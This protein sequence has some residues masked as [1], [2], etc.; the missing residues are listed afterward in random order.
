MVCG[1][2]WA[3]DY[4]C[5]RR[6]SFFCSGLIASSFAGSVLQLYIF[7]G[8]LI[9][10]GLSALFSSYVATLSRWFV[11]LRALTQGI[12]AAGIGVGMMVMA[13]VSTKL[14]ANYGWRKTF[15][16]ISIIGIRDKGTGTLSHKIDWLVYELYGLTLE[17]IVVVEGSTRK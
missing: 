13:P 12:L 16:I 7:L 2:I 10:C 4:H 15:I 9:G 17:E 5:C 6:Y 1:Q 8:F 14:L 11:K 3:P